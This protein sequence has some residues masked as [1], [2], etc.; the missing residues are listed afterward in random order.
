MNFIMTYHFYLKERNF[1]NSKNL[2]DKNEY[3]L[4]IRNLSQALNHGLI[5]KKVH[6][7][8]KFNE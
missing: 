4:H 5:L 7:V 6:G 2:D 3:L 8:I 1:K